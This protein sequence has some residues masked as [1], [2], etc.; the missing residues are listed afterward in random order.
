MALIDTKSGK[1]WASRRFKEM[2]QKQYGEF[3]IDLSQPFESEQHFR[4][5]IIHV[6]IATHLTEEQCN[7]IA[8][9]LGLIDDESP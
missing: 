4:K 1:I 9:A 3:G 5:T 8:R 2:Y 6:T 7:A